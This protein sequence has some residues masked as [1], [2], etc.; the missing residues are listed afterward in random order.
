MPGVVAY[1]TEESVAATSD[2]A[3]WKRKI[4]VPAP[5]PS[6][7]PTSTMRKDGGGLVSSLSIETVALESTSALPLGE[8]SSTR[9]VSLPSNW[10]SPLI[11]TSMILEVSPAA[12]VSVPPVAT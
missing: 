12:N 2:R 10:V 8:D 11:V 4:E 7:W 3:T 5:V 6:T 1:W 9:K